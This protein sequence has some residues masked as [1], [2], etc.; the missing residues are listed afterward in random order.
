MLTI[1]PKVWQSLANFM[2]FAILMAKFVNSLQNV[3]EI[4]LISVEIINIVCFTIA[5]KPY[6][7]P[8]RLLEL[9]DQDEE[10]RGHD[11]EDAVADALVEEAPLANA[12]AG[13]L[14]MYDSNE[15]EGSFLRG[16]AIGEEDVNE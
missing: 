12:L 10:H 11:G 9:P 15:R 2:S 8:R 4:L 16:S 7:E 13:F 6:V 14:N 5:C 3:A 1:F